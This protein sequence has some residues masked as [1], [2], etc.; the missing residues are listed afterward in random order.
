[1]LLS[2]RLSRRIRRL[3]LTFLAAALIASIP[4]L[5]QGGPAPSPGPLPGGGAPVDF[6]QAAKARFE[7]MK[8]R[9]QLTSEQEAQIKPVLA[10]N[11]KKLSELRDKYQGQT[12]DPQKRMQMREEMQGIRKDTD[13]RIAKFLT[14]QQVEEWTKMRE[15]NRQMMRQQARERMQDQPP[16]PAEPPKK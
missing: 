5:A 15:E 2:P 1:M 7:N 11:A 4:V 3:V 8:Q 9:L 10:E 14:P 13:D 16:A 12:A 6:Q